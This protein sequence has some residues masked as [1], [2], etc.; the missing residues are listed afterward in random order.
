MNEF[1]RWEEFAL[2]PGKAG[3]DI[4]VTLDPNFNITLG[5]R[6]ARRFGMSDSVVM[7]F[8]KWNKIIGIVPAKHNA[9]NAFPLVRKPRGEHRVIRARSFCRY[10]GIKVMRTTAIKAEINAQGVLELDLK[11]TRLCVRN[12]EPKPMLVPEPA[13]QD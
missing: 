3:R 7:M 5:A 12:P 1:R 2:G 8:D 10:Y 9:P 6:A 11:F 13:A 4:H